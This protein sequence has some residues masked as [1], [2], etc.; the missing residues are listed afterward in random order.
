MMLKITRILISEYLQR[1][2]LGSHH[3]WYLVY[4]IG[5]D[6]FGI[7]AYNS[8]TST[9]KDSMHLQRILQCS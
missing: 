9:G 8:D 3:N 4:F 6:G 2:G 7:Q 5:P 1:F